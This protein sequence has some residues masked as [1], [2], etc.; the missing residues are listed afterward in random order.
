MDAWRLTH[1][2]IVTV[3]A[4]HYYAERR[5]TENLSAA[6][7]LGAKLSRAKRVPKLKDILGRKPHKP[8]EDE[9]SEMRE[10]HRRL[11]EQL[12]NGA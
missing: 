11:K 10:R 6:A 7:W 2:E 9:L 5:R 3:L 8:S 4:A 1:G 12:A